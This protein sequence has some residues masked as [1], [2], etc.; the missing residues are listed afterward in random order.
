MVETATALWH[1]QTPATTLIA[2]MILSVHIV[3]APFLEFRIKGIVKFYY[4]YVVLS[5]VDSG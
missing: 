3:F 1:H 2:Y 5:Q 4:V